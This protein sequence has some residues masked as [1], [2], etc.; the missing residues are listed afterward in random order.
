M[1]LGILIIEKPSWLERTKIIMSVIHGKCPM[2][3]DDMPPNDGVHLC[4]GA[5]RG[6]SKTVMKTFMLFSIKDEIGFVAEGIQFSNG[7]CVLSWLT[8][9]SSISIYDSI[10]LIEKMYVHN[11]QT[12]IIWPSKEAYHTVIG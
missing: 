6:P 9:F 5:G 12:E 2:C 10:E 1:I 4:W 11:G 3:G 8:E 7:T